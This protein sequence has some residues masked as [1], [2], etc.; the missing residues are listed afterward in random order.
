[1]IET[2]SICTDAYCV[3]HAYAQCVKRIQ[4]CC[5]KTH[6][7]SVKNII[8]T[9]LFPP[10]SDLFV[11]LFTS[12]RM[13]GGAVT[14]T[15]IYIQHTSAYGYATHISTNGN[16]LYAI[17]I[18]DLHRGYGSRISAYGNVHLLSKHI[19][20]GYSEYYNCVICQIY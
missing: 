4:H 9:S 16:T 8:M 12:S 10:F 7:R 18:A 15:Y 17:R 2:V 11:Y 6:S 13:K 3:K 5:K 20:H 14:T 19:E 1:M